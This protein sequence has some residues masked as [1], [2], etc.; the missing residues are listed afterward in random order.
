VT[1]D[2]RTCSACGAPVRT[3]VTVGG[4]VRQLNPAPDPAGNHIIIT[5]TSGTVRSKTLTGP[6]LPALVEA[7]TAHE[8]P[9]PRPKGPACAVCG[10]EMDREIAVLE[11][12][13][14]HPCCDPAEGLAHVRKQ[15]RRR[16]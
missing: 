14:M 2:G 10:T 3:V 8:C 13:T 7:F 12:W 16:R 4:R 6:E 15:L 1:E 5:T 9:E 11:R